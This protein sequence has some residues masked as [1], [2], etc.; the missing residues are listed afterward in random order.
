MK[1]ST[2]RCFLVNLNLFLAVFRDI[3]PQNVMLSDSDAPVLMDFG[4]MGPATVE[5]KN[6]YQARAMQVID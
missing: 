4:S 1:L 5:I 2:A 6:S 3:K